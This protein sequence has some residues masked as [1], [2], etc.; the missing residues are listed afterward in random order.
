MSHRSGYPCL[1]I[2]RGR[3][4][5]SPKLPS[6]CKVSRK[7]IV[8]PCPVQ[9]GY[10]F[11]EF[12]QSRQPLER[13]PERK[14]FGTG[15]IVHYSCDRHGTMFDL[16]PYSW[17]PCLEIPS[18][19]KLCGRVHVG[20]PCKPPHLQLMVVLLVGKRRRNT[21]CNTSAWFVTYTSSTEA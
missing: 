3:G 8:I 2:S 17:W 7:P 6:P 21:I 1:L 13:Q 19:L 5:L 18:L 16:L 10:N 9:V 12:T 14:W 4:V 15:V 11:K 20:T